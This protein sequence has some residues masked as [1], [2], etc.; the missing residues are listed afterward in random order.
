[1]VIGHADS[2]QSSFLLGETST[3]GW[4]Y[5]FPTLIFLKTPVP[6]LILV[7][8]GLYFV[9]RYRSSNLLAGAM[10]LA[11][12]VFLGVAMLSKANLGIRHIMPIV[13]LLFIITG[14]ALTQMPKF[15]YLFMVLFAWMAISFIISYP[16]YLNYYNEFAGGSYNGY[17]I[18]AD[19]NT[20]WGQDLKRIA[21]YIHE[22]NLSNV[23]LEYNWNGVSSLD[24]YL[25]KGNYKQL[26]SWTP[27]EKGYAIIGASAYDGSPEYQFL[28]NCDGLKQITPGVMMCPLN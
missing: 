4:W 17:K 6:A 11:A 25:G 19:S 7:G 27:G 9:V 8:F 18:A 15:K 28:K 14:Y 10:L 12:G 20:D 22:N 1:M 23:Y 2:G 13:P 3:T 21:D 24:Y 26:S 5:Y 16:Y